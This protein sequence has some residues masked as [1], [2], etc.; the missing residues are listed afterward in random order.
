MNQIGNFDFEKFSVEAS[1]AIRD[2]KPLLGATGIFTPLLK[3]LL[4]KALEGEM[5]L[6]LQT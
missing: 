4:E 5:S 6:V 1:Q 3:S 2:G